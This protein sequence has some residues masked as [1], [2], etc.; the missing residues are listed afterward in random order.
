MS[1]KRKQ[2][3]TKYDL[4]LLRRTLRVNFPGKAICDILIFLGAD[5][6]TG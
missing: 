3:D 4:I 6:A 1:M 2:K 5:A